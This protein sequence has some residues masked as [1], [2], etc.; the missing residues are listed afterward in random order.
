MTI[1][2]LVATS[3][4]PAGDALA[5]C[6]PTFKVCSGTITTPLIDEESST[7]DLVWTLAPNSHINVGSSASRAIGLSRLGSVSFQ[8][9]SGSQ[10]TTNKGT[11]VYLK[12]SSDVILAQDANVGA[13]T[14]SCVSQT[15]CTQNDNAYGIRA[16]TEA[17]LTLALR[18]TVTVSGHENARSRAIF[19]SSNGTG[20]LVIS[21]SGHINAGLAPGASGIT[22]GTG[23]SRGIE[24]STTNKAPITIRA[25]TIS[26]TDQ[27]I[28]SVV[29]AGEINIH[30]SGAISS[31]RS[32]AIEA[33]SRS[34]AVTVVTDSTVSGQNSAI[35]VKTKS[36]SL[37]LSTKSVTDSGN[38]SSSVAV[39]VSALSLVGNQSATII[40]TGDITASTGAGLR[41][42]VT[43]SSSPVNLSLAGIEASKTALYLKNTS[44]DGNVNILA[45]GNLTTSYNNSSNSSIALRVVN[46]SSDDRTGSGSV[47]ITLAS[48]SGTKGAVD[49]SSTTLGRVSVTSTGM[50]RTSRSDSQTYAARIKSSGDIDLVVNSAYSRGGAIGVTSDGSGSTNIQI[51]GKV[52]ISGNQSLQAV[53]AIGSSRTNNI[54]IVVGSSGH[55]YAGVSRSSTTG[56]AG[57]YVQ[58][59][60]SGSSNVIVSGQVTTSGNDSGYAIDVQGKNSSINVS[61]GSSGVVSGY[62]GV[63][64]VAT[65][66]ADIDVVNSGAIVGEKVGIYSAGS[67]PITITTNSSITAVGTTGSAIKSSGTSDA[68]K[69]TLNNGAFVGTQ[70]GIGKAISDQSG[71]ANV[72]VNTGAVITASIDLGAGDDKLYVNGGTLSGSFDID[73]GNDTDRLHFDNGTFTL[74]SSNLKNWEILSINSN[75]TAKFLGKRLSGGQDLRVTSLIVDGVL[76]LEDGTVDDHLDILGNLSGSGVIIVD[77]NFATRIADK[78]AISGTVAGNIKVRLNDVT[79]SD[80][81][82]VVDSNIR[83]ISLNGSSQNTSAF[84]LENTSFQGGGYE[85]ILT[86]T[87]NKFI[88]LR[89]DIGVI[90]CIESNLDAGIFTCLGAISKAQSINSS[91]STNIDATLSSSAT[92]DVEEGIAFSM[93]GANGISFTQQAG[94]GALNAGV[95]ASGIVQ[96]VTTGSG[97]V[98]IAL[99]GQATLLGSGT[100]IKVESSGTSDITVSTSSVTADH[101]SGTAIHVLGGGQSL[102]I[103]TGAVSAG[104]NAIFATNTN[105]AGT[106]TINAS[107]AVTA[108]SGSGIF[109]Y[110]K[111]GDIRIDSTSTVTSSGIAIKAMTTGT[112]TVTIAAVDV[113]ASHASATAIYAKTAGGNVSITAPNIEGGKN[114]IEVFGEGRSADNVTVSV[115]GNVTGTNANGIYLHKSS[116]GNLNLTATGDISGKNHGINALNKASGSLSIDVRGEVRNQSGSANDGLRAISEG[117]G[118]ISVST[119]VVIGDD[120]GIEIRGLGRGT[121]TAMANGA[122]TG[123]GSGEL[124]AGILIYNRAGAGVATL[125]VGRFGTVEGSNGILFDNKSSSNATV[126]VAGA[127]TGRS[128]DGIDVSSQNGSISIVVEAN[129]TGAN[130]KVGIDTHTDGGITNIDLYSGSVTATSGI[131]IR[132]DEGN[133][134]VTLH[135]GARVGGDVSLGGGVDILTFSGGLINSSITLDG[136]T[137]SGTDTSVDEI[138]FEYSSIFLTGVSIRNWEK[139][140][141][142][143]GS[144]ISFDGTN[145]LTATEFSVNGTMSMQDDALGDELELI[146]NLSG[147]GILYVDTDF[148]TGS[149]DTLSVSGNITGAVT[150]EVND[151]SSDDA[152]RTEDAITVITYTGT[153]TDQSVNLGLGNFIRSK[154]YFYTLHH[155]ASNKTFSLIGELGSSNCSVDS[156]GLNFVCS[157]TINTPETITSAGNKDINAAIDRS[158]NARVSQGT[159]FAL[160]GRKNIT[161]TQDASGNALSATG[162]ATGVIHA[163]TAG[164]GNITVK[165]TGTASLEASGTAVQ[166]IST[167]SGN[168]SVQVSDVTAPHSSA[169]AIKASGRGANVTIR[170]VT[171]SGGREAITAENT[172]TGAVFVT[173]TGSVSSS[174]DTAIKVTSSGNIDINAGASV[175]AGRS[176]ATAVM[177]AGNGSSVNVRVATASSGKEAIVAMNRSSGTVS[178]TTTGVISSS[179]DT[180]IKAMSSG[181]VS[182]NAGANVTASGASGTAIMAVGK[183]SSVSVQATSLSA[184]QEAVHAVNSSN[185]SVTVT[186][187]GVISS[188]GDT[189]IKAM[190][191][192]SV[193]VNAGANVTASGASGTAIMA[194]GKGSSVSVQATS[195]SAGQEAVHAVNSSNGA[196]TVTTTGEISSRGS[197]AIVAKGEGSVSVN[198]T[199]NVTGKSVGIQAETSGSVSTNTQNSSSPSVVGPRRVAKASGFG[200]ENFLISST[201]DLTGQRGVAVASNSDL[202][203]VQISAAANVIGQLKAGIHAR[204]SG[205]GAITVSANNVTGQTDGI[206]A[207]H[208]GIGATT[209]NTTGAIVGKTG[210]G[211]NVTGNNNGTGISVMASSSVS[212]AKGGILVTHGGNGTVS[213]K[214]DGAISSSLTGNHGVSIDHTGTGNIS[215]VVSDAVTGGSN[216]AGINTRTRSGSASIVLNSGAVVSSAGGTA[217]RHGNNNLSISLNQGATISGNVELG[218]GIDR[219]MIAGGTLNAARVDGGEDIGSD[220]SIDVL[221]FVSGDSSLNSNRFINWERI[222]FA[223]GANVS[224]NGS[225]SFEAEEIDLKGTL[226]MQDNRADDTLTVN[227]DFSGGGTIRIDVDF[228]SGQSDS[229]SI[230]GSSSGMTTITIADITPDNVS[231]R[232]STIT[233]ATVNGNSTATSFNLESG[234]QFSSAGYLY[235]LNFDSANNTYQISG[236]SILGSLLLATPIAL[237]DGFARAPSLRER[238]GGLDHSQVDGN[239]SPK[240]W[241]RTISKNNEYGKSSLT[242]ASY[243]NSVLG[244]QVGAD[245]NLFENDSGSWLVGFFVSNHTVESTINLNTNSGD[246]EAS[247]YGIGATATWYG[248]SGHYTD[249]RVQVNRMTT[250]FE[251]STFGNVVDADASSA[252]YISSEFGYRIA[253]PSDID[254]YAQAQLSWGQIGLGN[255]KTTGGEIALHMEDGLTASAGIHAEFNQDSLNWYATG[256]LIFDTPSQWSTQFSNNKT[257]DQTSAMLAEFKA[258][259]SSQVSDNTSLFAQANISTSL[260]GNDSTRSS[261]GISAGIRLSW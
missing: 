224:V 184:G 15:S 240:F 6:N 185:G 12:G 92:V 30:V 164:S 258:G 171:A 87:S 235:E 151:I 64:V 3:V 62:Q 81:A 91:G 187:T 157:G 233:I 131:A 177:A 250:E 181:S 13:I 219:F 135:S 228:S 84:S 198:T 49:V 153:A 206:L 4:S 72:T 129:V 114:G 231:S 38:N 196:V 159:A 202:T 56:F 194:V 125:T 88:E 22:I 148:S 109:A 160:S 167:G 90:G 175:T 144:T 71:S 132:N 118:D 203:N 25:N 9:A 201:S 1:A 242:N 216:G 74:T 115:S 248:K 105:D 66:S 8:M 58:N 238:L 96:A 200:F 146:G 51:N 140:S 207:V 251:A 78:V 166:A 213:V 133:S 98:S 186:T 199:G 247:G 45:S 47:N 50:L 215:L 111:S 150:I 11:G 127:V 237:F 103:S 100:A 221:T 73:G 209:V 138:K 244:F 143:T 24:V 252:F 76:S 117:D 48:V 176:T 259:I 208:T 108:P 35:T 41:V 16:L 183:G 70:G 124:D 113:T 61:I 2:A 234:Y 178:V 205:R 232:A 67:G 46:E 156:S 80:S 195:V 83:V 147:T 23:Y 104:E 57:I 130:G 136:G 179:G 225:V 217:I 112:G 168:I 245:I 97:N 102:S 106:V 44:I 261:S 59:N 210:Y 220:R 65:N 36:G 255:V 141:V 152:T 89:A 239:S 75:A 134:F 223:S 27:A 193:S 137:D 116:E 191:S 182:V 218:G 31:T 236:S 110:S 107:G 254:I 155:N 79:P 145:T 94:G 53:R 149:V 37:L 28:H 54:N 211:L 77:V 161:F 173:T 40:S 212:G 253:T 42:V 154:N 26:A 52:S 126:N 101:A 227:G 226:S 32:R 165:L 20:N 158:A 172:G 18:G 119:T 162:S 17:N 256:G 260:E 34:G 122:V 192:G 5:E 139:I 82:H 169:T 68:I 241:M 10:V 63:S 243:D 229:I 69:I 190:S 60:G 249:I 21:S 170:A 39:D 55:V 204:N 222:N 128:G 93:S 230:S 188:N 246:L 180:A 214:T 120:E 43:S 163:A 257:L 14:S 86:V 142:S 85:Y 197:S 33:Y 99:V 123:N 121:L 95:N 174:G 7:D 29:P 19:A 189:A